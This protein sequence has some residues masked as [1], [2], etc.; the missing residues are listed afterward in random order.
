MAP[1]LKILIPLGP[2]RNPYTPFLFSLK[3]KNPGKQT[4]Y[5]FLNRVPMERDTLREGS[6]TGDPER[7]V[8]HGSE[9]GVCFHR[10]PA[11]VEH[12]GALLS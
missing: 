12:A 3:K 1:R 2:K 10:D 4:P 9:M 11:F 6:S 7:Y 8:K 5:R